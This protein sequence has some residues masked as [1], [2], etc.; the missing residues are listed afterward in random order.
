MIK[1][2]DCVRLMYNVQMYILVQKRMYMCGLA[3][4][5]LSNSK[6]TERNFHF[7]G[8][9]GYNFLVATEASLDAGEEVTQLGFFTSP[10]AFNGGRTLRGKE[11]LNT[12]NE[13]FS[14]SQTIWSPIF[15]HRSLITTKART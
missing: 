8:V 7:F 13:C 6:N 1:Q 4:G 10:G 12:G 15:T 2:T 5:A 3:W 9:E 11:S 14:E